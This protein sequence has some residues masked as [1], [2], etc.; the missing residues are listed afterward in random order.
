MVPF[1]GMPPDPSPEQLLAELDD[2]IRSMPPRP[3]IRHESP[4]NMAWFGRAAA[5]MHHWDPVRATMLFQSALDGVHARMAEDA[6]RGIRKVIVML[7]QARSELALKAG[8]PSSVA[9]P[10]GHRYAYFEELRAIIESAKQDLLFI[11]AYLDAEF[12]ERFLPLVSRGVNV[13]LLGRE[14]IAALVAAVRLQAPELGLTVEVRTAENFHDRYVFVDQ[15]ACYQSGASFKDG[16][17]SAS[18]VVT[19]IRDSFAAVHADYETRWDAAT[20]II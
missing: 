10:Q 11:D 17:K 14:R 8:G 15:L 5:V 7:H 6:A 1:R 13:R 18:T 3:T 16:A 12:A 9:I 2:V 4:E 20:R 19:Q